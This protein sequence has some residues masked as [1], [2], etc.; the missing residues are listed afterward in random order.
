MSEP[1]VRRKPWLL[2]FSGVLALLIATIYHLLGL[3]LRTE[4]KDAGGR[5]VPRCEGTPIKA[6]C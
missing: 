4:L 5:P 3:P 1:V 2:I 6:L